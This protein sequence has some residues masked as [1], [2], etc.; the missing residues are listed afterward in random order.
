[1]IKI[2]PVKVVRIIAR[3]S[4]QPVVCVGNELEPHPAV[5]IFRVV[6]QVAGGAL[7]QCPECKLVFTFKPEDDAEFS[8]IEWP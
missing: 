8:L 5:K 6:I 2:T 1:M 3:K 7:Y 4:H